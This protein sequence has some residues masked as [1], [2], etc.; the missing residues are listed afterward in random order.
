MAF[1]DRNNVWLGM[2]LG[3]ITPLAGFVLLYFINELLTTLAIID[4]GSESRIRTIL[5]IA[6]CTN[7][8]WIRAFN[9]PFTL[10][11]LRGLVSAT[12][13]LCAIWFAVY[14]DTLYA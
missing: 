14:F 5:I 4:S 3:F 12:M 1:Y 10:Q 11:T 13:L 8:Y 6:V 2:A 7:I 9:Q